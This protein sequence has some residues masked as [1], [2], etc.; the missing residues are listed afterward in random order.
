MQTNRL[1]QG[2]FAFAVAM[3]VVIALSNALTSGEN[4]VGQIAK[5]M[6]VSI[7]LFGCILPNR[8]FVVLIIATG[9]LDLL[10]RFMILDARL[11]QVD[12]YYVLG[13]APVGMLGICLGVILRLNVT[14]GANRRFAILFGMSLLLFAV[15]AGRK[16]AA[17]GGGMAMLG[18]L[19]N[20]GA[21]VT[22]LF[23]VP[24]L[25]PAIEQRVKLL[26]LATAIFI[27]VA[28]Y[29]IYQFFF[30]LS[31]FETEYL[32]SGFT[33]EIR[34]LTHDYARTNFST[35]NSTQAVS[36]MCATMAAIC[37]SRFVPRSGAAR[38]ES[39]WPRY[40]VVPLF[41]V[42]CALTL[43]RSGWLVGFITL[44]CLIMFRRRGTT[45]VVYI[46]GVMFIA[47]LFVFN[48]VWDDLFQT[49]FGIGYLGDSSM[50]R[51]VLTTGTWR[52]RLSGFKTLM[53]QSEMLQPFGYIFSK[54]SFQ[55]DARL[56][57]DLFTE[58]I[59]LLGYV[60]VTFI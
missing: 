1:I 53:T 9:Y 14:G 21:Y 47:S 56:T 44:F 33:G 19:A 52:E 45:W 2:I 51:T 34:H 46:A 41:V 35:L 20:A 27:P 59:L 57:H 50:G 24:V 16:I 25:F 49:Q 37:L 29:S 32:M 3:V 10:K 6:T 8:A 13:F 7:G 11:S 26:K 60:P 4:N 38:L 39:L 42:A 58:T 28:A 18:D 43:T 54:G 30:G 12:L 31:A 5:M 17:L 22:M 55:T 48:D 15:Q 23:V 40:I 36:V